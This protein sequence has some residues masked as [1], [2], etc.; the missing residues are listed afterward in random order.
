MATS[1]T[2]NYD[3]SW[4]TLLEQAHMRAGMDIE[5]ITSAQQRFAINMVNA[6]FATW[7]NNGP[8]LWAVEQESEDLAVAQETFEPASST[9]D[10]LETV[11]RYQGQDYVLTR[12]SREDWMELPNKLQQGRPTNFW[13]DKQIPN[14][15]VYI[16]PLPDVTGYQV[17]YFRM[18]QLMDAAG[19]GTETFNS[20][21]LWIDALTAALA[22]R[23]ASRE[24][25]KPRAMITLDQ[26]NHLKA[27]YEQVYFS[28]VRQNSD[29]SPLR[30]EPQVGDYYTF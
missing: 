29:K 18:V 3:L 28:A 16:W 24:A 11:V 25:M 19:L 21:Y 22:Y 23:L 8:N 17:R 26:V 30:L 5:S 12:F 6:I 14:Y 9:V 10:L 20:P 7:A 1:G 27:E 4:P 13:V 15:T 2:Y